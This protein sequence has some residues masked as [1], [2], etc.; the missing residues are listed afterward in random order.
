ML[1]LD[2][3]KSG[4]KN[5]ENPAGMYVHV[6]GANNDRGTVLWDPSD[7]LKISRVGN[8]DGLVSVFFASVGEWIKKDNDF[9]L[10]NELI[11]G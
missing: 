1:Y 6:D 10:P 11:A 8:M 3:T 2:F 4:T 7:G 9:V 5:W